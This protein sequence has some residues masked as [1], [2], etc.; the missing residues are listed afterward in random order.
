MVVALTILISLMLF[1]YGKM[2]AGKVRQQMESK[3][4]RN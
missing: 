3:G 4:R 1:Y 2:E